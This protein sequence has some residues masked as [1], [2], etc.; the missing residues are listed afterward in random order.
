MAKK[1]KIHSSTQDFTEIIE[2]TD[3]I[4]FF[5]GRRACTVLEISSVNFFL[6]S[7]DE[8]NARVYGYMS[9]LNSLSFFIQ[10]LVVS[11]RVDMSGYLKL[12][13]QKIT[14][15]TNPKISQHLEQY[16]IFMQDL[17]KGD[18]LLDKK[19]YVIIPISFIEM[20]A[21][22]AVKSAKGGFSEQAKDALI[23]KRNTVVSQIERI[24]LTART[25]NND[26]MISLFYEQFNQEII[27]T[28]FNSNDIKNIV[29]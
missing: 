20:G 29:L 8:Q 28:D 21:G 12:L 14:S 24:G 1:Q 22:S 13:D 18:D 4:A 26:E 9:L 16:R 17:I 5:K 7:Q 15:A 25:L 23:S 2:V 6:L 27:N 11:K 10:I 3:G 19:T